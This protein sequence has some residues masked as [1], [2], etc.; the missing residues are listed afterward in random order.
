MQDILP[1]SPNHLDTFKSEFKWTHANL[2][3]CGTTALAVDLVVVAEEEGGSSACG[4]GT[5]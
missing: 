3:V 4:S 5:G 2:L 1:I